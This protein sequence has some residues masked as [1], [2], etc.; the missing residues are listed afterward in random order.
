VLALV[1]ELAS[2][3]WGE[4]IGLRPQD[5]LELL[6]LGPGVSADD[7][8]ATWQPVLDWIG[9]RAREYEGTPSLVTVPFEGFWDDRW[10]EAE[11]PG[12]ILRDERPGAVRSHFWWAGDQ[13]EV[14]IFWDSY[15]SRWIPQGMFEE[16]PDELAG[17]LFDASRMWPTLGLHLNKGLGGTP[18]D[19]RARDRATSINPVALDAGA[20]LIA[21]A[22]Q[23]Y[24]FP[25]V[26]GHEPDR[27][28]SA[29]RARHITEA[30][31][32]VRA[33]TPGSG[34]YVNETD[35]FEPDWQRSFWGEHYPRLL[36]IKRRYDPTNLFRVHHGV[37][38]E[39]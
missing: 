27:E 23:Q 29:V 26:D 18:A 35:Y 31:A 28:L 25:G 30:M 22:G 17:I 10:R 4:Q 38:S 8:K 15:Q 36:E 3:H 39:V 19:A 9:R 20:L 24:A 33:A 12:T 5:T 6:M 16:S 21:A 32:L 2:Q 11:L 37:G 13:R 1:P 14:S 34:S 7:A